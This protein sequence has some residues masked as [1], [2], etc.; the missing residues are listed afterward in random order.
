M[1]HSLHLADKSAVVSL[2]VFADHSAMTHP[3][4]CITVSII[5]QQELILI[6]FRVQI[7]EQT[8]SARKHC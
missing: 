4:G 3:D 1:S 2:F 7:E 8:V 5:N 6:F